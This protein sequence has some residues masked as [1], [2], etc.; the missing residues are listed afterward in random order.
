MKDV[1]DVMLDLEFFGTEE[2]MV[3]EYP[4]EDAFPLVTSVG[5]AVQVN[6]VF[7]RSYN[8]PL[9]MLEQLNNGAKFGKGCM[10]EFWTKQPLFGEE[11]A[12]SMRNT[13]HIHESL[14]YVSRIIAGVRCDNP[15]SKLNVWG[16]SLLADNNKLIRLYAKYADCYYGLP[17]TYFEH[18]DYRELRATAQKYTNFSTDKACAKLEEAL[19][20]GVYKEAGFTEMK[21]HNAEFDCI[22]QLFILNEVRTCL[23]EAKTALKG[24]K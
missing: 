9:N 24:D 1:V 21:E 20:A 19:A 8:I 17:F 16:N 7:T 15:D 14:L 22:K 5:I 4:V 10:L 2:D 11:F 18:S 13:A 23:E 12:R 3:R 6:G